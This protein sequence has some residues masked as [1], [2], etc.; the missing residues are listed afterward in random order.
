LAWQSPRNCPSQLDSLL[1]IP[2]LFG[3]VAEVERLSFFIFV[4]IKTFFGKIFFDCD[5]RLGLLLCFLSK[6]HDFVHDYT[7]KDGATAHEIEQVD[8]VSKKVDSMKR[9]TE[10]TSL[11]EHTTLALRPSKEVYLPNENG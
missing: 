1:A 2:H 5:S 4:F 6:K 9:S 8:T 10:R 3:I 7:H 11:G